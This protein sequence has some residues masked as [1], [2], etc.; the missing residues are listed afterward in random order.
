MA[1]SCERIAARA[2]I[3]AALWYVFVKRDLPDA[4]VQFECTGECSMKTSLRVASWLLLLAVTAVCLHRAKAAL[5]NPDSVT[6]TVTA[7]G[8]KDVAPPPITP[9]DVQVTLSKQRTQVAGWNKAERLYLAVVIDD[10]LDPTVTIQ[11]ND[12]KE[13]LTAQPEST[14][15]LVGY[16][17][18]AT[19]TV[20][21]DFTNDHALAAKALR[22]PLG[23]LGAYGSPYLS[24]I[25]LMKRWS[26][27]GDRRSILLIS[28]GFDYFRSGFGP[29]SPDLDPAIERAEKENIN[30]WSIYSPGIGH[31]S[32]SFFS[33]SYAQ[34]N[35]SQLSD[36]TGAES[37]YLGFTAAVSFKPYLDEI[38][39]HL[40]NQYLLT[41]SAGS[42]GGKKGK[43]ER[44]RVNTE[45][46]NVEFMHADQVFL[47]PAQ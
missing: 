3:R 4:A 17:R 11:W 43:F 18:N 40:G 39:T 21:Q 28:S 37:Y 34:R 46:D 36:E 1:G 12:L 23:S 42:A 47:P 13:F 33:V 25:D 35:L 31:R 45:L 7:V 32:R 10:S 8:K 5:P 38:R 6:V 26:G 22:I 14:Y 30:I 15:E 27:S 24:L 16:A 19:V 29:T 2:D 20:A 44:L 41:F 9:Q